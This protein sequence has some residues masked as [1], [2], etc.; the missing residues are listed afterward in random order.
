MAL[1]DL[2]ALFKH[3][4]TPFAP[5][6][7]AG[8]LS[9]YSPVDDDH[10]VL[11]AMVQSA[12]KHLTVAMYGFDD[13]DLEADIHAKLDDP[14][15]TVKLVLD[16]SQ[17]GGAHEKALLAKAAFPSNL[18]AIGRSERGAIMHLKMVIVD[19]LD[20]VSG[21]TNWSEGGE[22]KQDNQLTVTRDAMVAAEANMRIDAIF[23]FMTSKVVKAA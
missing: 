8:A 12:Q 23:A 16:S 14:N 2:T 22:T 9:F 4:K 17:A 18:I 10:A 3:K 11:R 5:G 1:P 15:V 6:Y 7:P 21:S 13:D 20:T 19:G